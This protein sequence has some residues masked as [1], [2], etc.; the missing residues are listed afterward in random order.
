MIVM[1]IA[2]TASLKASSRLV[3]MRVSLESDECRSRR[4]PRHRELVSYSR[5]GSPG[6][7]LPHW[8]ARRLADGAEVHPAVSRVPRPGVMSRRSLARRA[9]IHAL[10]GC[11]PTLTPPLHVLDCEAPGRSQ[12]PRPPGSRMRPVDTAGGSPGGSETSAPLLWREPST[13]LGLRQ[14]QSV[15]LVT[16]SI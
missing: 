14:I 6:G 9:C 12:T 2:S 7:A 16:E 13:W 11:Q 10:S 5:A 3:V 8:L 4:L 1:I 15:K